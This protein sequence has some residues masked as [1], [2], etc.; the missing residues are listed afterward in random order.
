VGHA[1]SHIARL[2]LLAALELAGEV[3]VAPH[4]AQLGQRDLRLE[5]RRVGDERSKVGLL[6]L[7]EAGQIGER[8]APV[9]CNLTAAEAGA[10]RAIELGEGFLG[11]LRLAQ[12]R[13]EIVPCGGVARRDFERLAIRRLRLGVP[14]LAAHCNTECAPGL[15]IAGV[16]GQ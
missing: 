14:A 6:R 1:Q 3:A 15:G 7:V 9:E 11:T 5:V 4:V 12:Q 16:G 8:A 10:G 2:R 13:A